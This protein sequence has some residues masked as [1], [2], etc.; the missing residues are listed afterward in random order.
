M[1]DTLTRE[2]IEAIE[3]LA[4]KATPGDWRSFCK[5]KYDEWHV[6]VPMSSGS[7]RWALF[8]DGVRTENP[9]ADAGLIAA[10][11]NAWPALCSM[12]LRSLEL[13]EDAERWQWFLSR[14]SAKGVTDESGQR[15][16]FPFIW[17]KGTIMRGSVAQ[18]FTEAI[19][20]A[21]KEQS[22]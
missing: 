22:T 1:S 2:E 13:R 10:L 21:R 12:A 18:H 14:V 11:R 7:S 16:V 17:P 8:D 15:F 6:S 9:E 4:K 5:S 19:D 20:A 3:A